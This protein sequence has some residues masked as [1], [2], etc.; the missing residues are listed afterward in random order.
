MISGSWKHYKLNFLISILPFVLDLECNRWNLNQIMK[1]STLSRSPI[2]TSD[3][4]ALKTS[5]I[6]TMLSYSAWSPWGYTTEVV[7]E[8]QRGYHRRFDIFSYESWGNHR[9]WNRGRK[10]I[11][12]WFRCSNSEVW[13]PDFGS[14]TWIVRS[15]ARL[16]LAFQILERNE[17]VRKMGYSQIK[18]ITVAGHSGLIRAG[19]SNTGDSL[20]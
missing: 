12:R 3:C 18:L 19:K 10:A 4:F 5:L 15:G 17:N 1:G 20:H 14:P 9:K 6:T 2:L 7:L 11:G 8:P 13:N 16:Y